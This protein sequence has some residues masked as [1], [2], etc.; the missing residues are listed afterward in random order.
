MKKKRNDILLL[1]GLLLVAT[2]ATFFLNFFSNEGQILQIYQD[3]QLIGEYSLK[4]DREIVWDTEW[5]YNIIEIK[6]KAVRIKEADCPD[7][8]CV[9]HYPI[10]LSTQTIICLPHRLVLKIVPGDRREGKVLE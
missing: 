2:I 10:S 1:V 8:I 5:G 4:Q 6:N 7:N 3:N 9:A